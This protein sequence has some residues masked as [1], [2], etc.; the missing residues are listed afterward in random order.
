MVSIYF[1]WECISARENKY[2]EIIFAVCSE[3]CAT[4]ESN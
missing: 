1:K 2:L 4:H 3:K